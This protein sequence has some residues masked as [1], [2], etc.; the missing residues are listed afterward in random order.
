MIERKKGG[1]ILIIG[2]MGIL[3]ALKFEHG[4]HDCIQG[5]RLWAGQVAGESSRTHGIRANIIAPGTMETKISSAELSQAALTPRTT[6]IVQNC[7]WGDSAS[8]RR[9]QRALFWASDESS[10]ITGDRI[11]CSGGLFI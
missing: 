10:Y 6:P 8:R 7:Q 2:G 5:R 3:T 11:N 9:W 4:S 1:S